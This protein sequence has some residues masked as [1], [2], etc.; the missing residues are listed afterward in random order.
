[1]RILRAAGGA[2]FYCLLA[3]DFVHAG[4]SVLP[5]IDITA[6]RVIEQESLEL[7]GGGAAR[8]LPGTAV[9]ISQPQLHFQQD[10]RLE[11]VLLRSGAALPGVS[12]AG[13]ATAVNARGFGL[14]SRIY[15]NGHPDILRLFV[16]DLATVERV[17]VW[18]GHLALLYGQGSPGATIGY[19]G[20]QASGSGRFQFSTSFGSYGQKRLDLDF[21]SDNSQP[22]GFFY[23][24]VYAGQQGGT[25][26]DHVGSDRESA[27]A[28]FAWRYGHG[29][30]LRFEVEAQ[31]NERPFSFGT[32]FLN[33]QFKFDRSYVAP[34]SRSD[35]VYERAGVYWDHRLAEHWRVQ[36][37]YSQAEVR[38]NE[39]LLG[40][41]SIANVDTLSGYYR[42]LNDAVRQ[43]NLRL[44]LRGDV[45]TGGL[46]HHLNFGLQHDTQR[47]DFYGPQN[48]A[49]FSLNANSP[50]FDLDL[51]SLPLSPRV[52]REKHLETGLYFLDRVSFAERWH[53]LFGLRHSRI[54]IDTDNGVLAKKATDVD[55]VTKT[56][57]LVYAPTYFLSLYGARSESFEPNRGMDR[58]G[59]YIPPRQGHQDELGFSLQSADQKH[60]LHVAKFEITQTNLTTTDPLDRTALLAVGVVRSQGV[61]LEAQL[62]VADAWMLRAQYTRQTVR[63]VQKTLPG[64][65]DLLPGVPSQFAALSLEKNALFGF[66][67][68]AWLSAS[69]VGKRFGDVANTFVAPAY[70]R[71]D[72]A[73][74]YRFR[75]NSSLAFKVL[76]LEDRRYVEAITAAD[77]V[78]Q[79]ERRRFM[80]SVR[81]AFE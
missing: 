81:H 78:F 22:E 72:L 37:A 73:S 67:V 42:V 25:F 39:T 74:E 24:A 23:R 8:L 11:D 64:L 63:N 3:A 10:E 71:L 70:H 75:K 49:G 80:L 41:W 34:Q 19:F 2:A 15:Y 9:V 33:G 66:P 30:Q 45:A 58:F 44:E 47:I 32:V 69:W 79:G 68:R 5:V 77:N 21:D 59:A 51:A 31:R 16:R 35:R 27:Y 53:A 52:T 61:E 4:D 56:W 62:A 17:E 40:F 50:Q 65:G 7:L 1:M 60:R 28:T 6:Q 20:K 57:G 29:N 18:K 54:R 14:A 38:R 12:N 48:I 43:D 46:H 36:A 26:I 13:L 55:A 76:N